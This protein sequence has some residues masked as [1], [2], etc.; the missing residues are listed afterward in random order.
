VLETLIPTDVAFKPEPFVL[1][2][3][4]IGRLLLEVGDNGA[5]I[6]MPSTLKSGRVNYLIFQDLVGSIAGLRANSEGGDSDLT[7]EGGQFEAKGVVDKYEV[8]AFR[9]AGV[10]A[11]KDT[12]HTAA[13]CTVSANN[14]GPAIKKMLT[15]GLYADALALCRKTGY[16]KNDYYIYTNT[17]DF[18]P[19]Q[20]M[21]FVFLP[22]SRV[23][24][25]LS[26][27]DPRLISRQAI[28]DECVRTEKVR[29]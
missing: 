25:L 4:T 17:R 23:L 19:G 3:V 18:Q 8:K 7:S 13:S 14:K 27:T 22:T 2:D 21:R 6:D 28:L 9:E 5:L 10:R 11:G 26:T 1:Y 16:D 12:F 29:I 20:P 24:E 15:D